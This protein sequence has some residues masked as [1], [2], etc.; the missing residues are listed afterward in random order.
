MP[1][2]TPVAKTERVSM[3][4]QNTSANHTVK[5]V[6][7]W[8][9]LLAR[10]VWNGVMAGAEMAGFARDGLLGVARPV[11]ENVLDPQ[12][13]QPRDAEGQRE[14]RIVAPGFEGVDRLA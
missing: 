6:M 9:R 13:E 8:T 11:V 1:P 2:I 10:I 14:R 4:T 5:L 7:F 3:N 12:G